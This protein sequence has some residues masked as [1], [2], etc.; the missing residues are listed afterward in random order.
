MTRALIHHDFESVPVAQWQNSTLAAYVFRQ[1]SAEY[2]KPL[3]PHFAQAMYRWKAQEAELR[4]LLQA[5]N[6]AGIVPLLIKGVA[7][8]IRFYPQPHERFFGD[9]DLV[10]DRK[11]VPTARDIAARLGWLVLFDDSRDGLLSVHEALGLVSPKANL[12]LDVHHVLLKHPVRYLAQVKDMLESIQS[13]IEIFDWD[14][15]Q[16][17]MLS[18]QDMA[19][20]T[21]AM[22]R[23]WYLERW[24]L[25]RFD[26]VDLLQL[27]EAGL[28]REALVERAKELGCHQTLAFFLQ[29]CDPWKGILS[30]EEVSTSEKQRWSQD[31]QPERGF[32]DEA[33]YKLRR[34]A[35]MKRV[36][37]E[38]NSVFQ[39]LFWVLRAAVV[40]Q[41]VQSL[42]ALCGQVSL[43]KQNPQ[44]KALH[45]SSTGVRWAS[46]LLARFPRGGSG[47]CVLRALAMLWWLRRA[48]IDAELVSGVR[49]VGGT[50]KGH[51]WIEYRN[52]VIP[53]IA[54][55]EMSPMVYKV[56]FRSASAGNPPQTRG[57]GSVPEHP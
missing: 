27:K 18:L 2:R 35:R 51:A 12:K 41:R 42:Q 19:L 22:H 57:A 29:R 7:M 43:K 46:K 14:G 23:S 47:M 15:I 34:S 49:N 50:L 11:D 30:T 6:D 9:I 1:T 10:L 45:R 53:I 44:L 13:Q 26:Y 8:A 54:G 56:N 17:K 33:W 21:L 28:T 24:K 37:D 52:T 40:L 31:V 32:T 20:V 39:G 3:L 55:D 5:W 48:G 16:V 4:P 25:K 38:L 36:P